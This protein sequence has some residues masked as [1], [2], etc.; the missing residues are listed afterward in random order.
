M[1]VREAFVLALRDVEVLIP[2]LILSLI[3]L[4]IFFVVAVILNRL[5]SKIL[6]LVRIDEMSK[7]FE[8]YIGVSFSSFVL[9]ITNVVIVLTALYAVA[10]VSFPSSIPV[11]NS[12]LEYVAKI[13]S[14]IFLISIV[15]V[16]ISKMS[17]KVAV[18]EKIRSFMTLIM[19]FVVLVLLIDVTNLSPEVKS[20]LSWGL[21][22]GIGISIGVFSLW[23]FFHETIPRR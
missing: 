1:S 17:E 3:V 13:I 11:V 9:A 22:V 7:P 18:E 16:A 19:L 20:A 23:Y 2:K 21:S 6:Q 14:V 8:K 4:L 15:F 10:N 5:F 12:I